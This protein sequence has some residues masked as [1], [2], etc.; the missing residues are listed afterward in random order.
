MSDHDPTPE[1]SAKPTKTAAVLSDLERMRQEI[2]AVVLAPARLVHSLLPSYTLIFRADLTREELDSIRKQCR[3]PGGKNETYMPKFDA[4][5]LNATNIG[6]E[7]DGEAMVDD[8]GDD[9]A[10]YNE[11]FQLAF[12]T[13]NGADCA[14]AFMRTDAALATMANAVL[15]R[16]GFGREVEDAA[17]NPTSGR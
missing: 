10:F 16:T 15:E 11:Q 5:V 14:A 12:E 8:D 7:K 6:I 13:T 2:D 4:M 1:P 17:G 9:V 3:K